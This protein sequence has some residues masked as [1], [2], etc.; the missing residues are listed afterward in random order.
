MKLYKYFRNDK[1]FQQT[2]K[3]LHEKY[4]LH[5]CTT[6]KD[7]AAF[8]EISRD[9]NKFIKETK[10][11]GGGEDSGLIDFMNHHKSQTLDWY[12]ITTYIPGNRYAA[13]ERKKLALMTDMEY[14]IL[15][16]TVEKQVPL[17]DIKN[18]ISPDLFKGKFRKAFR[19]IGYTGLYSMLTGNPVKG[20]DEVFYQFDVKYDE[21][22][23]FIKMNIELLS[24][25][26]FLEAIIDC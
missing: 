17:D 2:G 10:K 18:I 20:T 11:Y 14:E 21:L 12:E 3:E 13:E 6:D 26:G 5:A 22:Q 4:P 9:M 25:D 15:N 24:L 8:F 7:Y 23:L 1:N 16:F 19:T